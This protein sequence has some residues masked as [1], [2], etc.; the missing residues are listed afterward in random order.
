MRVPEAKFDDAVKRFSALGEVVD[1]TT[2]ADDVSD[3]MVDLKARLRHARA[4]DRRLVGFL[5]QARN[6]K[7]TLAVQDRID[8]NQLVIEQLTAEIA[9]MSE[10]TSYG[11]ITVSM[12]E[13][14]VPQPGSIDESDS[15]WGAFTNS[16]RLIADGAKASAVALGARCRSWPSSVSS[17]WSS[18]TAA[19]RSCAAGRRRRR[20][21]RCRRAERGAR[22]AARAG[23]RGAPT[24]PRVSPPFTRG[25]VVAAWARRRLGEPSPRRGYV[26]SYA[27]RSGRRIDER[28]EAALKAVG[29]T[30]TAAPRS[31]STRTSPIP[32]RDR[33]RSSCASRRRRSIPST[34]RF[35]KIASR[36]P[37]SRPRSSARTAPAWWNASATP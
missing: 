8:A 3:Q 2:S 35:A 10:V 31:S 7:E 32:N 34:S 15:F 28:R 13:R 11:T 17:P 29:S 22:P 18:G 5:D 19:G 23:G 27:R 6:V 36:R 33:S 20:R 25:P 14:G 12:H 16:L 24:G 21:R 4:V 26:A 1:L 30:S 9:R 37:S